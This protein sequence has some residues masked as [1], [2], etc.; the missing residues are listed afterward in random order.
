[1]EN[2]Y[3]V[4]GRGLFGLVLVWVVW[5]TSRRSVTRETTTPYQGAPASGDDFNSNKLRCIRP[6]EARVHRRACGPHRRSCRG[7]FERG[8]QPVHASAEGRP[9]IPEDY[10]AVEHR[11]GEKGAYHHPGS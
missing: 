2:C 7:G 5:G 1:H 8:L 3:G 10:L 11:S 6:E 9:C 4:E